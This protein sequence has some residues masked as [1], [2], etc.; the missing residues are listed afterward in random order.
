MLHV[1]VELFSWEYLSDGFAYDTVVSQSGKGTEHIR[2]LPFLNYQDN[3][4]E[5]PRKENGNLCLTYG[6][7]MNKRLNM[8]NYESVTQSSGYI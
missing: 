5:K 1:F 2:N 4:L 7:S 3:I 8:K 6:Y